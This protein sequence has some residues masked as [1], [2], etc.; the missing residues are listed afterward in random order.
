[1]SAHA[2]GGSRTRHGYATSC[3]CGWESPWRPTFGDARLA[4][5]VHL[6]AEARKAKA[7]ADSLED[8]EDHAAAVA[9][10]QE[11]DRLDDLD[12]AEAAAYDE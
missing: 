10:S 4:L 8:H 6:A 1:M 5:D 2:F 11:A 9:A 7:E 3:A 12:A